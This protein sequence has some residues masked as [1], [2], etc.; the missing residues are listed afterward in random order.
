MFTYNKIKKYCTVTLLLFF[1]VMS[2]NGQTFDSIRTLFSAGNLPEAKQA[3]DD[4][5]AKQRKDSRAQL[6]KAEIYFAFTKHPK[7]SALIPNGAS[8]AMLAIKQALSI[9]SNQTKLT[10]K[11]KTIY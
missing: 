6:L 9:D 3:I 4:Y 5:L 2:A 8:D 10:L 11:E 7:Y 1:G